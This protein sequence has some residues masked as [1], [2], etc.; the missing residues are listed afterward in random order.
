MGVVKHPGSFAVVHG[1]EF[2]G[3]VTVVHGVEVVRM[4]NVGVV[5]G[6]F[7][8]SGLVGLR[9]FPVVARG[10]V[11]VLGRL[12]MMVQFRLV[13]HVAVEFEVLS[14]EL[15]TARPYTPIASMV[16]RL[17]QECAKGMPAPSVRKVEDDKEAA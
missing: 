15:G 11:M 17:R 13:G 5:P 6:L 4:R 7:V 10:L 8:V 9:C 12:V 14:P 1:V 3:L 2:P 16:R